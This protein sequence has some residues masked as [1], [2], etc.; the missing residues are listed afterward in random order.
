MKARTLKDLK[1]YPLVSDVWKESQYGIFDDTDE[2]YWLSLKAGYW[3]ESEQSSLIQ[4]RG[5]VKEI[6]SEFNYLTIK[7]D[8]R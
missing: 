3:F 8:P 6:V 4:T 5:L 1:N 7:K 2:V